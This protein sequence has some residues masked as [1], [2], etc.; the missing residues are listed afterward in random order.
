M[1]SE[2]LND[3]LAQKSGSQAVIGRRLT[4]CTTKGYLGAAIRAAVRIVRRVLVVS[5]CQDLMD[6]LQ[7]ARGE[8]MQRKQVSDG[9]QP[10]P[11]VQVGAMAPS[12][13]NCVRVSADGMIC[14]HPSL[15]TMAGPRRFDQRRR[16][17]PHADMA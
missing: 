11:H 5:G 16:C 10:L 7:L 6:A 14:I 12:A 8:Q 17:W 9:E 4:Q 15:D 1:L 3:G 13:T 2:G